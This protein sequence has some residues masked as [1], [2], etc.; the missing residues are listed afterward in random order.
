MPEEIK[1]KT[2][3][4]K[5]CVALVSSMLAE[6]QH[7][8]IRIGELGITYDDVV[9]AIFHIDD[10]YGKYLAVKLWKDDSDQWNGIKS[11]GAEPIC[12]G[13]VDRHGLQEELDRQGFPV[14]TTLKESDELTIVAVAF[15]SI[16]VFGVNPKLMDTRPGTN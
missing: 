8:S 13:L 6:I 4:Q 10:P 11:G 9:I 5:K 14:A 12:F 7:Y 3:A 16:I 15:G 2:D 1:P